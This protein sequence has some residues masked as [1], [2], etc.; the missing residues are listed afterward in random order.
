MNEDT[1]PVGAEQTVTDLKADILELVE[2]ADAAWLRTTDTKAAEDVLL[3]AMVK[4]RMLVDPRVNQPLKATVRMVNATVGYV[5][6]EGSELTGCIRGLYE[7][8]GW[9][10]WNDLSQQVATHLEDAPSAVRAL[11]LSYGIVRLI[12]VEIHQD[13]LTEESQR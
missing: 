10:V 2:A 5:G 4:I 12:E 3:E 11:A 7:G 9:S 1:T 6:F 13:R 8:S